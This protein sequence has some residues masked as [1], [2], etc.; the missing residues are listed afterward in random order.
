MP[1]RG[2]RRQSF[3][4]RVRSIF[5]HPVRDTMR[6]PIADLSSGHSIDR[7]TSRTTGAPT[8]I[9]ADVVPNLTTT[10]ASTM[11]DDQKFGHRDSIPQLHQGRLGVRHLV[12]FM[13][14]GSAPFTVI[15]GG[16]TTTFAVTGV[17]GV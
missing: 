13:L 6:Q 4:L 1:S 16:V 7:R 15:S 9:A 8:G 14:A 17:V 12:F 5:D 10:P 11:R 2:E 3:L